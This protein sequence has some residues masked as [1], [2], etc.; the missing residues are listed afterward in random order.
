V[1]ITRLRD[2][3]VQTVLPNWLAN[4]YDE[5]AGQFLEGLELDGSPERTGIVRVRS[6]A[7]QIYVYAH[8][9]A[10]GLAPAGAIEKAEVAFAN[11]RRMAWIAGEKPGYASAFN[12]RSGEITDRKRELYDHACVLLALA[13]LSKATG[14]RKY[15]DAISE[16]T[17]A[18]DVTLRS[19]FGGWAEDESGSLPRRQN[20]HMH[21]FE[22]CLALWETG[23]GHQHSARAGEL[24]SLFRSRFWDEEIGTLREFFG[25]SWEVSDAFR[26][27][28]LDPGHMSEWAWLITRY[29]RL[30]LTDLSHFADGLLTAAL[31][32]GRN[33]S[34]P[35][36]ADEVAFDGTPL[37]DRRRLWP[38]A[39]LLKAF[40]VRNQKGDSNLAAA[41]DQ[42]ASLL[43]I[44]YLAGAAHG[45]WRDAF[46]LDGNPT[47]TQI[48]GSSLY[49]LWT[50]IPEIAFGAAFHK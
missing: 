13:W 19:P 36:L 17:S 37:V 42:F 41:A 10:L 4:A 29:E 43:L 11:M 30:T 8:A 50:V 21:Y 28:R 6:T 16:T 45:T 18:I 15:N 38:Q 25:P 46:D 44:T 47:A 9:A 39:E 5:T 40:V 27:G 26:S 1:S 33:R 24:F 48:P 3:F 20:P 34:A 23:H 14:S 12:L 2:H 7:R 49:H 31:D 22:A 32:L 35:F